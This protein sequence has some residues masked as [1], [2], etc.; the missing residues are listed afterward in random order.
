MQQLRIAL[1]WFLNPDHLPLIAARDRLA[2]EGLHIELVIPD[3]HYDGFEA[4]AAGEVELVVNEP[5][6]LVEQRACKLRS[7][8][9]FFATDGGVLIHRASL[10]RLVAGQPVRIASPVSNPTTDQLCKDILAAWIRQQGGAGG[11]DH[12][13]IEPAGFAH[14]DNLV[15]GYDGAWLA[16]ANVEGV[17]AR[18]RGLDTQLITTGEAGIP[19]FSA[20]ELIGAATADDATRTA[21]AKL[22]AALDAVIPDLV[23]DPAAARELWYAASGEQPGEEVDAIVEASLRKFIAP[24]AP[25][26]EMWRPMWRYLHTHGGDVVDAP[27]F[28][29]MFPG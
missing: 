1:E 26:I 15:A 12:V 7:Y 11:T 19:N 6:H 17:A 16:F 10:A 21:I 4:L 28:E 18:V 8:G 20:L 27:A 5:L 3:D 29:A 25:D 2:R 13:G 14:V 23:A 22:V 24:V 9:C